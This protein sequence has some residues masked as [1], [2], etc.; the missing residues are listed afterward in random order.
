[1]Q[2]QPG[3]KDQMVR[4]AIRHESAIGCHSTLRSDQAVCRGFFEAHK[5]SPLQIAERMGMME[6]V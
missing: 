5:T 6:L 3:R 4:D 1:M 2:L